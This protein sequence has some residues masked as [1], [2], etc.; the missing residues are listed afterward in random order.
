MNEN[1]IKYNYDPLYVIYRCYKLL[2]T[3][4][5]E[6]KKFPIIKELKE[7][8]LREAPHYLIPE[9]EEIIY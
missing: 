8:L 6:G 4:K 1:T 3:V 2:S 9:G 5:A 7:I